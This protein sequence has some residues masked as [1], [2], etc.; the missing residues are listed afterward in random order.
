[1][2]R[3]KWQT[4]TDDELLAELRETDA[5]TLTE[6]K[7][8]LRFLAQETEGPEG[9]SIP[10]IEFEAGLMLG[11]AFKSFVDGSFLA[12]VLSAQAFL[13]H[14]LATALDAQGKIN[15]SRLKFFEV[16]NKCEDQGL[17]S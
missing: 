9:A 10:G 15:V 2:V 1:M 11:D 4:P 7:E 8:R 17:L 16:I 3:P 13:E 14:C 5:L 12:S 6:R